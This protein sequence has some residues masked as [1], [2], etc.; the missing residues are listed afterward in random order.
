MQSEKTKHTYKYTCDIC[1]KPTDIMYT[2]DPEGN[3]A[4]P[5]EHHVCKDHCQENIFSLIDQIAISIVDSK[6]LPP[7][8]INL[9]KITF[10]IKCATNDLDGIHI[11]IIAA[12]NNYTGNEEF[13]AYEIKGDIITTLKN[14]II[15]VFDRILPNSTYSDII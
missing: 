8:K 15:D 1:G 14:S 12:F 10:T 5:V 11:L 3:G 7:I 13:S 6:D 2:T 4:F 9:E